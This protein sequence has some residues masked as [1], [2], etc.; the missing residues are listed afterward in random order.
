[1]NLTIVYREID[2]LVCDTGNARTH[3]DEQIAQIAASIRQWGWTNPI[4]IDERATIVAGHG[5]LEAARTL[6]LRQVPTITIEGLSDK[7]RQALNLADN[8]LALNAGWD[9]D[10]LR[11]GLERLQANAFDLSLLG[12]SGSKLEALLG[13]SNKLDELIEARYQIMVDCGDAEVQTRLLSQ[14]QSRGIRC[15]GLMDLP[16]H[17]RGNG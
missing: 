2:E 3:S 7:Q 16:A 12:F 1:M 9:Q 4:L 17:A 5:R 14:F 13:S 11:A 10:L 8:K 6:S 15:K